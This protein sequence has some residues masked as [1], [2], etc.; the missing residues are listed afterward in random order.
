M[1]DILATSEFSARSG[2]GNLSLRSE[3]KVSLPG[4]SY[5]LR[6]I[7]QRPRACRYGVL[8]QQQSAQ[9]RAMYTPVFPVMRVPVCARIYVHI[10]AYMR[11][12]RSNA[13]RSLGHVCL[14]AG[15]SWGLRSGAW[16][17]GRVPELIKVMQLGLSRNR[18]GS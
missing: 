14:N 16:E 10:C 17:G 15:I 13:L 4:I 9:Y 3:W 5:L 12:D 8:K 6:D 18:V 11:T 2:S 7:S 1:Q